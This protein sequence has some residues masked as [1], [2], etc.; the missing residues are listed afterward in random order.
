MKIALL[1]LPITN[2]YGC[3]LQ[4]WALKE[5][6]DNLGHNVLFLDLQPTYARNYKFTLW[7][8]KIIASLI[9]L[10]PNKK[11][12]HY[13]D[14]R[15]LQLKNF[16]P[17]R[18]TN[19]IL[20]K[21]IHTSRDLEKV[22]DNENCEAI[23]VGSDQVWRKWNFTSLDFF[24]LSWL[25]VDVPKLGYAI[26]YGKDKWEL[27]EEETQKYSNLA[28]TFSALSMR[29]DAGVELTKKYL[30]VDS[31]HV[32]DPTML[33]DIKDYNQL[34]EKSKLSNNK[35]GIF[36]YVLD[37]TEGK[38]N[39]INECPK[40][41]GV[42]SFDVMPK[43]RNFDPY[44]KCPDEYYTFPPIEE[45]L[46]A[47]RSSDFVITDSFHGTV[48]SIIY[49]KPFIVL[50]NEFRG[51]SR[52]NSLLKIFGLENRLVTNDSIDTALKIASSQIAWDKVN[53][54]RE[55]WKEKSINFLKQ[56]LDM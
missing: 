25:K 40:Y 4:A 16:I 3:Y 39:I 1:T 11:G 44:E 56:N 46:S 15:I 31:I 33:L 21:E 29:E 20:S 41:F 49:N 2:N 36:N 18:K 45:W 24:F 28:K 55:Q 17:F 47:F 54:Q 37:I 10:L 42:P 32:L 23:V 5:T 22:F 38:K 7:S 19:F 35:K 14:Y 8:K 27:S 12:F 43:R 26:S 6:L 30:G 53:K 34:I 48:F 9:G 50:G 13:I 51:L 52:I